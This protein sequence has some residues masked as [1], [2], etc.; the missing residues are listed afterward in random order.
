[1]LARGRVQFA[2]T[3]AI[4]RFNSRSRNLF[5][6]F[7]NIFSFKFV[8]DPSLLVV[9]PGCDMPDL[10]GRPKSRSSQAVQFWIQLLDFNKYLAENQ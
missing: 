9:L 1:M 8:P 4:Q 7:E 5:S 2:F 6:F 3:V 10:D